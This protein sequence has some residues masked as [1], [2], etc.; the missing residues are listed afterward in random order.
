MGIGATVVFEGVE[1]TVESD[2]AL[3]C[4]ITGRDFWIT[5]DHLLSGSSVGHFGDRGTLVLDRQFADEL[6]LLSGRPLQRA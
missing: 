1:V 6:G 2:L 5:S 3:C 4:R